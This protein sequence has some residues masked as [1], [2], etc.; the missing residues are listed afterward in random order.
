[1]KFQYTDGPDYF[2][3]SIEL[4][5]GDRVEKIYLKDAKPVVNRFLNVPGFGNELFTEIANMYFS[6]GVAFIDGKKRFKL[7]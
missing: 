5:T 1:M 7:N 6:K 3:R 4:D 2:C